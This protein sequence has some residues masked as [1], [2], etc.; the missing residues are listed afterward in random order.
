MQRGFVLFLRRCEMYEPSQ[1]PNKLTAQCTL[2]S[3]PIFTLIFDNL[4]ILLPAAHWNPQ[5]W[6]VI[7]FGIGIGSGVGQ[8]LPMILYQ[9]CLA[10]RSIPTSQFDAQKSAPP[11]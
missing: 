11:T 2:F 10:K 6:D 7:K 1:S 4:V 3:W 5:N 8:I 9:K